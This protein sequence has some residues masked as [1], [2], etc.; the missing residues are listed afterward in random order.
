MLPRLN[1]SDEPRA[2][3]CIISEHGEAASRPPTAAA[4]AAEPAPA[5]SDAAQARLG[6]PAAEPPA[7]AGAAAPPRPGARSPP[8]RRSWA[9]RRPCLR[10]RRACRP[11][12]R[13]AARRA[14]VWAEAVPGAAVHGVVGHGRRRGGPGVRVCHLP[15]A[16]VGMRLRLAQVGVA[17]RV[18][19]ALTA[20]SCARACKS[21]CMEGRHWFLGRR[22]RSDEGGASA[23]PDCCAGGHVP[24]NRP[25]MRAQL[26]R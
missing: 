16:L 6:A 10:A 2:G 25:V 4:A 23:I 5:A 18:V 17:L 1:V 15:G 22:E 9:C 14:L 20:P 12:P 8:A 26:L 13:P 3:S 11:G 21:W 19:L 7:A 24:A